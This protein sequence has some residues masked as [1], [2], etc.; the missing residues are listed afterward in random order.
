MQTTT[1]KKAHRKIIQ[2]L[3]AVAMVFAV[4]AL[5]THAATHLHNGSDEAR[6][7]V[8]HIGHASAPGPSAPLSIQAPVAVARFASIDEAFVHIASVRTPSSPRAPPA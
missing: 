4:V 1:H 7:Q 8:C 2:R 3:L 6:C 5:A